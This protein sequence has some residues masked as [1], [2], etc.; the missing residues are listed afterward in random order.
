MKQLDAVVIGG[1][2]LGCFAARSLCRWNLRVAL[3]EASDDVCTGITR[4]NA[5]VC[6]AGYDHAPDSA[7]ATFTAAANA[8]MDVLCEELEVPFTRPGGL[9]TAVGP[10]GEAVLRKKL[11]QGMQKG[12]P[13][14]RLLTGA[15]ARVLEP[16]LSADITAALYS[17]TTGTL[18]PWQFGIA[19]FENAVYNSCEPILNTSVRGIQRF[20]NGYLLET[21]KGEIRCRMIL[22]CAGLNADR[23]QE[24]LFPPRVRLFPDASDFLVFDRIASGPSHILF[25]E[26]EG[27][28][29]GVTAV[30]DV[31]G[32][33]LLASPARLLTGELFSTTSD[34][35]ENLRCLASQLLPGLDFAAI[36]RSF[37][38]VRPNARRVVFRDGQ[39]LPDEKNIPSFVIDRPEPGFVSL[40]G[41]KTPG[42]TCAD[43]LGRHLA[44]MTAEYLHAEENTKFDPKRKAIRKVSRLDIQDRALL[45]ARD[46]AYGEVV[47]LCED[48]TRGEIREAIVRGAAT[49]AGVKRRVGTGMGTCQGSRCTREIR[50]LLGEYGH[51]T[52]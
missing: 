8:G 2:V 34:G 35:L 11:A 29:K 17:P 13:G 50:K 40:I 49:V 32:N 14:L 16:M 52:G 41:I 28:G 36:I 26:T 31:D 37:G 9:M 45:A 4:A 51:G 19:A 46:P 3:L 10:K 24:L 48:I 44:A 30:P 43:Q 7:K 6:Y 27:N 20:G 1:G 12:V 33:L 22:N 18:N 39:W 5:A 15:E 42:L 38:A 21:D 25:Q 47:C 23:V